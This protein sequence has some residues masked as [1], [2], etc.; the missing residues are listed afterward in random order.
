M[1]RAAGGRVGSGHRR[2]HGFGEK[3]IVGGFDECSFSGVA[4]A[5]LRHQWGE[6][7][8]VVASAVPPARDLALKGREIWSRQGGERGSKER[9]EPMQMLT[10]GVRRE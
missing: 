6:A 3:D 7:D 8:G 4:E 1:S 5:E 2:L 9:F 10:C